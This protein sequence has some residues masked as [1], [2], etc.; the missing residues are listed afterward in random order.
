MFSNNHV[1][2]RWMVI[3]GVVF[4]APGCGDSAKDKAA[5]PAKVENSVTET[6]LTTVTLSAEAMRHL[7][8]E[9]TQV[10]SSSVAPTR[11]VGGEVVVP[12]GQALTVSAPVAGTVLSPEAGAIPLPG[13][14]VSRRQPL[15]RL[16]ALPAERDLLRTQEQ[17][18]VAEARLRQAQA[19]AERVARLYADRLV[20]ARE[21]E[22]AQADLAAAEAAMSA[23]A[24]QQTLLRGGS[25]GDTKGLS[26]LLV[27][28]PANGIVQALHVAAGQSVAAGAPLAEIVRLD[29]LWI[30]VP[31]YSGDATLFDQ[32]AQATVQG[33]SAQTGGLLILARPVAAPPSADPGSASVDLFYEVST[34]AGLQPGQRVSVTLPM[35][36]AKETAL[37]V[38]LEAV[39]YDMNGGTWV[40]EQSD[41][42]TFT[43]RRI[44]IS[45]V[46][47]GRAVLSRGPARGTRI[48]TAG[49]AEL[50]GTEFGSGK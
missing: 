48:V 33:L 17:F 5:P 7:G 1:A 21:N 6:S 24:S 41:S 14:R 8:I 11:V 15:M 40:Y 30:R 10:D 25:L 32:G 37:V 39:V 9:T 38:P 43:R 44:E 4:M 50:F 18:T 46:V 45:R 47:N 36:S 26:P 42:V 35:R 19:E 22:K 20:A 27:S 49:A 34:T 28:A 23:A 29:R 12:P 16:V 2:P 31:V 3:C 13:S